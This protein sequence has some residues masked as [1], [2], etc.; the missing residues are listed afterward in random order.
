MEDKM[1]QTKMEMISTNLYTENV[2]ITNYETSLN[3]TNENYGL[4]IKK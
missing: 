1:K 2:N 4:I 3:N